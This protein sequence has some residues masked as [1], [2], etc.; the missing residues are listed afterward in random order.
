MAQNDINVKYKLNE[1]GSIKKTAADAKKLGKET[2]NLQNSTQKLNKSKNQYQRTEKGSAQITSNSTKAFSKQAQGIDG[3]LVPAYATLAA[4]VFAVTAAFGVLQRAAQVEQLEQGLSALGRASGLAMTTLSK[5]LIDATGAAL[6]FE[7][8]MRSTIAITSAGL[9]PSKVEELGVAARNAS[10][11]LGRDM[12]DSIQRLTRGITKLEPE[13]LD[14]LGIF[15]RLDTAT[16]DYAR[17]MGK[18]ASELTNFEK[19]QAFANAVLEEAQQKFGAIGEE[20]E[21]N[22]FNRLA[23]TFADLSKAGLNV[24]NTIFKPVVSFLADSPMA[25]IGVLGLF[26]ATIAKTV[27]GSLTEMTA[28]VR[29]NAM[30]QKQLQLSQIQN[31]KTFG[32]IGKKVPALVESLKDGRAT[33]EEY[34]AAVNGLRMSTMSYIG[35]LKRGKIEEKDFTRIKKERIQL[36]LEVRMLQIQQNVLIADTAKAKGIAAI[37]EGRWSAALRFTLVS[38]RNYGKSIALA[39]VNLKGFTRVTTVARLS[40]SALG[41]AATLASAAIAKLFGPIM[42]VVTVF[43]LLYEGVKAVFNFFKSDDT[44]RFEEALLGVTEASKELAENLKEVDL[45]LDGNSNKILT[46]TAR[47]EAMFNIL[48][49]F[50]AKYQKLG[51]AGGDVENTLEA[52]ES[53]IMSLIKGSKVLT[54]AFNSQIKAQLE[55]ATLSSE[56]VTIL[57]GFISQQEK[58]AFSV[59]N[60]KETAESSTKSVQEYFNSL[61]PKTEITALATGLGEISKAL[62]NLEVN[63]AESTRVFVESLSEQQAALLGVAEQR[64]KLAKNDVRI[65]EKEKQI[66]EARRTYSD[67]SSQFFVSEEENAQ[68]QEALQVI[69]SGEG[70]IAQLRKD[71][72]KVLKEGND[73]LESTAQ[74]S[75]AVITAS[76][77]ILATSSSQLSVSKEALSYEKAKGS[78][79]IVSLKAQLGLK[80]TILKAEQKSLQAQVDVDKL[81]L[82]SYKE[83]QKNTTEYINLQ[84]RIK[85]NE[86]KIKKLKEDQL[87]PLETAVEL[88]KQELTILETIQQGEQAFVAMQEKSLSLRKEINSRALEGY[89]IALKQS[90]AENPYK[91]S[92][93]IDPKQEFLLAQSKVKLEEAFIEQQTSV[94]KSKA[95]MEYDLIDAQYALL[96]AQLVVLQKKAEA[97][98]DTKLAAGLGGAVSN[99]SQA[100]AAAI[101][102]RATAMA[103]I[104]AQGE[105]QK[106]V[107]ADVLADSAEKAIEFGKT[108]TG[109]F[110]ERLQA[111]TGEGGLFNI[112]EATTRDK[113][114]AIGNM[115]QPF[116]DEL[117]ALGPQGELIAGVQEGMFSIIDSV[118]LFGEVSASVLSSFNERTGSSFESIGDAWESLDLS[119]KAQVVAAAL[120]VVGQS[121]GALAGAMR[122]ASQNAIEGIDNQIEREKA[123][124]GKSAESVQKLK[125][126]EAKKEQMK[127]KAFEQ[128]KKMKLAQAVIGTATGIAQAL[129]AAPPPYNFILA[130]LV[131]AMGAAQ[132]SLISGMT[133][134]GGGASDAGSSVSSVSAGSRGTSVDMASSKSAAGELGYFRGQQGIG[135]AESFTP[136]FTGM[137]YRASGGETTGFMVGE[138]GPEMFVP[139]KPGRIVPADEVSQGTPINANINISAIDAQGVEEVLINQRGNIIGMI[140][141]AANANGET[142]LESVSTME[143]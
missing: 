24:I 44:K 74:E 36:E 141:E 99:V 106:R 83:N 88:R 52:Q 115:L 16:Q 22:P 85:A 58:A 39:S 143:I 3:G 109:S 103:S 84:N 55:D 6:S 133:Y 20:V 117:R 62:N 19:R 57:E 66:A 7:E 30:A 49:Q 34:E 124:D 47:Y 111:A 75:I 93:A 91:D 87:D 63:A 29:E 98:G 14:E 105:H 125:A 1:D 59:K 78:I 25:L 138:Q 2:E 100:Q 142:F 10:T 102:N 127:R 107:N 89:K 27:L 122:A 45:A 37:A 101:A 13:L 123:L 54:S 23:A 126:L 18:S 137:K 21:S 31:I 131:G 130:G 42:L 82:A 43:S 61:K 86:N 64:D 120:N 40:I 80:D 4:N 53:A 94:L 11:A 96:R 90:N 17:S 68:M 112:D 33:T 108:A 35:Q 104:T 134:N 26:G 135:G 70:E 114:Q 73:V 12:Q 119:E 5:G 28:K 71:N 139:E 140:R 129:S 46:T 32:T 97:D 9:D 15:V 69:R 116:G 77:K 65:A 8:A 38:M 121:L 72:V 95:K 79:S 50:D 113:V 76:E 51:Q 67:I 41:T 128:D 81:T 110:F 136:A 132:I 60:F 48:D 92:R 118:Q 56:R